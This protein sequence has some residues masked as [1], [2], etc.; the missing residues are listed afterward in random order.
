MS[1]QQPATTSSGPSTTQAIADAFCTHV[2]P[3]HTEVT[4]S[5][6]HLLTLIRASQPSHTN[7]NRTHSQQGSGAYNSD[8]YEKSIVTSAGSVSADTVLAT[9]LQLGVLSRHPADDMAYVLGCPALG[10]LVKSV[11]AGTSC[12]IGTIMHTCCHRSVVYG[13]AMFGPYATGLVRRV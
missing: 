9:L 1:A 4:I 13:T 6:S 12:V 11:L 7:H 8:M 2:V 5:Q 3:H 10:L